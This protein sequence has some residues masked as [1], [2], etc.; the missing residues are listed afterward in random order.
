ML[1]KEQ[2]YTGTIIEVIDTVLYQI[3]VE[4]PGFAASVNAF[5]MRGELDEPKVG[6]FVLLR[7]L[8]PIYNSY[9]L[10]QKIKENDFIG[11]RSNGK[12]VDITPDYI[13]VGIFDPAEEYNDLSDNY[14][15]AEGDVVTDWVKLDKDGNLFVNL[16]ANSE[17]TIEGNS[18]ITI[19]GDSVVNIEGNAE[20]NIK[21]DSKIKVDGKVDL[22]SP[23]VKITSNSKISLS[24]GGSLETTA[25]T[26]SPT[27][28]G[29]FC[30]IPVCPF[31]GAPHVGN[32]ITGI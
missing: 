9:F 13:M 20:T 16:R 22:S 18:N 21:G 5:P 7:S 19:K 12:I 27:G 23:E 14:R 17:I 11:F 8:D 1:N 4:I 32:K 24:G 26:C 29:G 6:D 31:T 15:P 3:K 28:M 25:G 10:Y 30:G 2:Y